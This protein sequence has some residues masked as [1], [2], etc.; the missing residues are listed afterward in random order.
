M[1]SIDSLD[2][3]ELSPYKW[4]THID[5]LSILA[6]D[7]DVFPVTV[8]LDLVGYCN[9]NCGWCVDPLHI[10]DCFDFS[11]INQL[12]TELK[13]LGVEGI[14]YKGGGEPTL[15]QYFANV[16]RETKKSGFEQ[17]IVTNGSRLITLY[18]SIVE[19]VNY[20]RVSIDGPGA[21]SHQRI[22]RS[23]DFD[24]IIQGIGSTIQLRNNLKQRHPVIGLSFAMDYSMI[25]LID[26]AI[27][28]G[29][30]LCIDYVLLRPPFFEEVGR[31]NMMTA[32][33]KKALLSAFNA[34]S[35]SYNGKMKIFIDY[36][37][38]DSEVNEFFGTGE[39]PRRGR[40]MQKQA[41][42]I[43]HIT[44]RC[45]ASPLLAVITAD[46]KIYPCCNLRYIEEWNIG[47]I[48]YEKGD[49]F[50]KIWRSNKRKEII[51]KIKNIKC[52]KYCTHP[53]SRYNEVIEYLKS[54]QYHKAF[55]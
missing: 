8:E 1:Y 29:E 25:D 52:I 6:N 9:H 17:G 11:F 18:D 50:E 21:E 40:Y 49:T 36:W 20:L 13:L 15:Y 10:S 41:N 44:G 55:I 46:K 51:N 37:I 30:N 43:E 39:S 5:K 27:K 47:T 31:K 14:V 2:N 33:N 22:H 53:L 42:G 38:S 16:I 24:S 28:L 7:G 32:E 12:L 34:K 54:P 19:N 48:D 23:N 4:A 35:K 3:V 45:F 26:E